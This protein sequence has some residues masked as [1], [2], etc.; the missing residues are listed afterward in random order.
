MGVLDAASHHELTACVNP[1]IVLNSA[2]HV[3]STLLVCLKGRQT[4][5]PSVERL[6]LR[7]AASIAAFPGLDL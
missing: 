4:L 3:L 6:V 2:S 1:T 7:P 5:R